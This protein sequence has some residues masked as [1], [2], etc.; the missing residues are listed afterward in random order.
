VRHHRVTPEPHLPRALRRGAVRLHEG[1]AGAARAAPLAHHADGHHAHRLRVRLRHATD[2]LPRLSQDDGRLA[3]A[4]PS[5]A[6]RVAG[7]ESGSRPFAT[8]NA[9]LA[10]RSTRSPLLTPDTGS[11]TTSDTPHPSASAPRACRARGS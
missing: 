8:G 5:C 10:T 2:V 1:T 6:L 7:C 3:T 4:V 9:Q 11:R